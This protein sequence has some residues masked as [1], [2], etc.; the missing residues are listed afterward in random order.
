MSGRRNQSRQTFE[1]SVLNAPIDPKVEYQKLFDLFYSGEGMP[2]GIKPKKAMYERAKENFYKFNFRGTCCSIDEFNKNCGF[3]FER[4]PSDFNIECLV[5]LCEYI[6]N[7][8]SGLIGAFYSGAPAWAIPV[9]PPLGDQF[10]I[11]QV[12]QVMGKLGYIEAPH[13]DLLSSS[14][15]W[16]V[17]Y[18]NTTEAQVI[19]TMDWVPQDISA[20]I[21]VYQQYTQHRYL[22]EKRNILTSLARFL[23]PR[24]RMLSS[25][26]REF[27]DN[28]FFLFNNLNIRHNNTSPADTKNFNKVIA[29]MSPAEL[30]CWYDI[31]HKMCIFAIFYL[32]SLTINKNIKELKRKIQNIK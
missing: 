14:F 7:I 24:R 5:L 1:Q 29:D 21:L 22:E 23:E 26:L 10:L 18:K 27:T 25:G 2:K 4:D 3:S 8:Y 15:S 12:E 13:K 16:V 31:I 30:G 19:A 28:L 11:S 32:D 6:K 9:D 20:A 17:Y